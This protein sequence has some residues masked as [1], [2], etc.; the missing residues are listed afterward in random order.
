MVGPTAMPERRPLAQGPRAEVLSTEGVT[1]PRASGGYTVDHVN[2]SIAA[3]EIVGIYGLMGA[4]RS[5]LFECLFGLR[6]DATGTILLEGKDI[7]HLAVAERIRRG[8]F[9][10]PEDRQRDGL[11]Q[12]MSVARNLTISSLWQ[13]TRLFWMDHRAE[14]GKVDRMIGTLR[15]KVSSPDDSI[16]A[17]SGGNQQKVVIGK[18]LLTSPKLLLLDEPTRGID[19]GAKAE[20]FRTMRQLAEKGLG[21][22]YATSDLKEIMAAADRIIVMSR[23]RITGDFPRDEATEARLVAASTQVAAPS[24]ESSRSITE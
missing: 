23:G 17:L 13:F 10:V 4:G 14:R 2:L 16:T 24:L 19:I 3:G 8:V 6:A 1:L 7:S 18:S 22:V 20:V 11:L 12:N 9:L 5:E 21:V 15:V